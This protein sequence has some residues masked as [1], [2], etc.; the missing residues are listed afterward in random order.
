MTDLTLT[1]ETRD[2]ITIVTASGSL[3]CYTAPSFRVHLADA[4]EVSH[5]IA[6]DLDAADILDS[7]CLGVIIGNEKQL[8]ARY[9]DGRTAIIC[10]A[11][12]VLNVF[13]VTGLVKTFGIHATADEAVAAL[14]E[15]SL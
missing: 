15:P 6:I 11:D 5:L 13:R 4:R 3:D 8:R 12:R 10:T 2:G 7:T 9:A 1:S 14:K